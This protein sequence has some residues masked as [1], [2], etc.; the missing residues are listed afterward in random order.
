MGGKKLAVSKQAEE[1]EGD[2]FVRVRKK[3]LTMIRVKIKLE[4]E[5][6]KSLKYGPKILTNFCFRLQSDFLQK[7]TPQEE[8]P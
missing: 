5:D 4:V 3:A 1:G 2:V 7:I 6:F 8:V